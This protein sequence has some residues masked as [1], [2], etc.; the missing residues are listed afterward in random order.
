MG[1][2][3]VRVGDPDLCQR[4]GQYRRLHASGKAVRRRWRRPGCAGTWGGRN[5][6]SICSGPCSS[7]VTETS[8]MPPPPAPQ[9]QGG[10]QCWPSVVV[11]GVREGGSRLC[12]PQGMVSPGHRVQEGRCRPSSEHTAPLEYLPLLPGS[13]RRSVPGGPSAWPPLWII[14]TGVGLDLVPQLFP[15]I[16]QVHSISGVSHCPQGTM[17]THSRPGASLA[18]RSAAASFPPSFTS[19]PDGAPSPGYL[20]PRFC[21]PDCICL[22]INPTELSS[23]TGPAALPGVSRDEGTSI[24]QLWVSCGVRARPQ[25]HCKGGHRGHPCY[26][27]YSTLCVLPRQPENGQRGQSTGVIM[28]FERK[29]QG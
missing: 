20:P 18:F 10:P 26:G 23:P 17:D 19:G 25:P 27:S 28:G 22:S 29:A 16:S 3:Q 2:A 6:T 13:P 5:S 1:E 9:H 7:P 11:A 21:L 14:P 12:H 24:S 8:F 15:S 4:R